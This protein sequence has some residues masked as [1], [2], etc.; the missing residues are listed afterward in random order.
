MWMSQCFDY[1]YLLSCIYDAY[2]I[3]EI[4]LWKFLEIWISSTVT[5]EHRTN[6]NGWI[7]AAPFIF[8]IFR[9]SYLIPN[10][11]FVCAAVT[12]ECKPSSSSFNRKI[13]VLHLIF[14]K[15][16]VIESSRVCSSLSVRVEL[17]KGKF[18][19]EAK[20]EK[21][22]ERM[23]IQDKHFNV[24]KWSGFDWTFNIFSSSWK[25]ISWE[26]IINFKILQ[27]YFYSIFLLSIFHIVPFSVKVLQLNT[28][29]SR[30]VD[31]ML[32]S[33]TLNERR[34]VGEFSDADKSFMSATNKSSEIDELSSTCDRNAV[35]M[36]INDGEVK[37]QWNWTM[38]EQKVPTN[39]AIESVN[40]R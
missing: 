31:F 14:N 6:V 2:N 35:Y 10:K 5:T 15:H 18:R 26:L 4:F 32:E 25:K 22:T 24:L 40:F 19:L 34:K 20:S 17:K 8:T 28:S 12:Y 33:T 13:W 7:A 16:V 29:T 30:I 3:N 37:V 23:R 39:D 36:T 1:L 38:R 11:C 27:F 9:L 21:Y